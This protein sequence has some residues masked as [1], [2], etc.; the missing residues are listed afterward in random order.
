MQDKKAKSKILIRV[1]I[2]KLKDYGRWMVMYVN[3]LTI[4]KL[5]ISIKYFNPC[6]KKKRWRHGEANA[7]ISQKIM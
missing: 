6:I 1:S 2:K 7:L 3:P 5:K 4:L